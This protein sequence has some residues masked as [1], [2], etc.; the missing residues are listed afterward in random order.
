[1]K[2]IELHALAPLI[3]RDGRPFDLGQ[4]ARCLPWFY[5]S[6][7][8]GALRSAMGRQFPGEWTRD[9]LRELPVHGPLPIVGGELY[10][11]APAD[12]FTY[13]DENDAPKLD[14]LNPETTS[15][16]TKRS[17]WWDC[18]SRRCSVGRTA[19]TATLDPLFFRP[20]HWRDIQMLRADKPDPNAAVWWQKSAMAR[21]LASTEPT[22]GVHPYS[23]VRDLPQVVRSHARI[24]RGS[25]VVDEVFRTAARDFFVQKVAGGSANEAVS[26]LA[27]LGSQQAEQVPSGIMTMG[28]ERRPVWAAEPKDNTLWG[29]CDG[30]GPQLAQAKRVRMLLATPALFAN[31]WLP[32]WIDATTYAGS[33]PSH[34][35][36]KL[37]LYSAIVPRHRG[38][39]GW[40]MT[41]N[42]PK[43]TR[44][45]AAAGSVYYFEIVAGSWDDALWLA[46][47]SDCEQDRRDGFGLTLWGITN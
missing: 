3:P 38:I 8:A 5:P 30:L 35:S 29:I 10:L 9:A 11:P 25:Q 31:G 41:S 33:P 6:T 39:S 32:G 40:D 1:M 28:A 24:D 36:L 7:L 42:T 16:P 34:P 20:A 18:L 46:P 37:K 13:L 43:P 14:R 44:R 22:R 19:D 15:T 27:R 47:V 21:W 12:A 2:S 23:Y 4:S 17:R 26:M 45:L